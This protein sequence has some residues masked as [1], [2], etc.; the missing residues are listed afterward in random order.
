MFAFFLQ[1]HLICTIPKYKD[2]KTAEAIDVQIVADSSGRKSE[3]QNFTYTPGM[4]NL[5]HL[6]L[7]LFLTTSTSPHSWHERKRIYIVL[8]VT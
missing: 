4:N 8:N 1:G 5:C 6:F 7:L 2:G 3:P